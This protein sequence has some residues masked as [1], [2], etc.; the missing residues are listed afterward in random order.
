MQPARLRILWGRHIK[1]T[2]E[3]AR[4]R[5]VKQVQPMWICILWDRPFEETFENTRWKKLKQM[6]PMRPLLRQ[7]IW[8]D[9]W[10]RTVEKSDTNATYVTLPRLMLAIWGLIWKSTPEK[11]QT[12]A[13]SVP[14]PALPQVLWGDIW[15]GTD[16][17][18]KEKSHHLWLH[19]SI[20]YLER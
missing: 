17:C 11:S 7:V 5:K 3:N 6:Q 15:R 1:E 4:W 14:L 13:T 19:I 9:N 2:F 20:I 18:R 12:N 10:K 8:G 16:Q